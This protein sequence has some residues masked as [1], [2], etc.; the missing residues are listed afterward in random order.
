MSASGG[1]A[2][3]HAP[4]ARLDTRQALTPR[5]HALPHAARSL[6][7]RATSCPRGP[8]RRRS[9]AGSVSAFA[10]ARVA[11][12]ARSGVA[13][14]AHCLA[15]RALHGTAAHLVAGPRRTATPRLRAARRVGGRRAPVSTL[16]RDATKCNPAEKRR[17]MRKLREMFMSI[18]G[19]RRPA[20]LAWGTTGLESGASPACGRLRPPA[21]ISRPMSTK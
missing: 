11:A 7:G 8:M 5:P 20:A 21:T 14:M 2:A 3:W 15:S 16:P 10:C 13:G 17:R 6:A 12:A 18:I 19:V 4:V 1:A 9:A